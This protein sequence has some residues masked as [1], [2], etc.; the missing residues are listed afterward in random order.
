M[1]DEEEKMKRFLLVLLS[2]GLIMAF[3]ASAFAVDVKVGAEYYIGG[4]YLNKISLDDG[5][6]NWAGS[7]GSQ[8]P[9]TAFFYQRLRVGTDFI[10]SPSLKLVTQFDAMERIWGGSRS[11]TWG[12]NQN[13]MV[14]ESAGTRAE[15]ENIA[16]R[17]AYIDYTSPIGLFRIGY[18][19]DYV[20]GTVFADRGSGTPA[21]QIMYM[22]PVGPFLFGFDY[23][24]E[25]SQSYSAVTAGSY[26]STIY[27]NG[28]LTDADSNSYR[29]GS[30]YNFKGGDAGLLF[31]LSRNATNRG[32]TTP[33]PYGYIQNVYVIDPYVKAKIGPVALQAEALYWFGDAMKADG[34]PGF[35]GGNTINISSLSAFVDATANFGMFYA[36]GSVAYVQ[37]QNPSDFGSKLEGGVSPFSGGVD[38]NP[39]LIMFNT[40]TLG[41]WAGGIY[42]HSAI[43]GPGSAYVNPIDGEMMNAWFGQLRGGVKPTPQL[44]IMASISYAEADQNGFVATGPTTVATFPGKTYGTEIDV[45][46]TYKITN[47]LSY[48]LG[49]GYFFAGDYFKGLNTAYEGGA[50]VTDDFIFI[51][52][53]TLSF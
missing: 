43:Y 40:Q 46:G 39:C 25:V 44:D 5:F 42:G 51:N 15:T 26:S 50:K 14:N 36:G 21:G 49:A 32:T 11:N 48:M 12:A 33:F 8:N 17:L 31:L 7:T 13:Y 20:W 30:I 2:L 22:V 35:A 23:A 28:Y 34:G 9:S 10:I 38:W 6:Q 24:K 37:G 4:L 47:N 1:D 18:Q 45:T 16:M 29:I 3:S 19:E 41:Y 52:K 53:L 27:N